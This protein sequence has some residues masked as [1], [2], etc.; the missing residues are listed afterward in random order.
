MFPKNEENDYFVIYDLKDNLIAYCDN[1]D[2]LSSFTN[3]LKK[4]L[5]FSFKNKNI[6]WYLYCDTYRK[7][8]KFSD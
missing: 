7:I 8:Y 4:H 3:R 6:V 1:L 5:K 2:E